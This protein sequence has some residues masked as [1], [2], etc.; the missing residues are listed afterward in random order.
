M[1][2]TASVSKNLPTQTVPLWLV[3]MI[4]AAA[5]EMK[6]VERVSQSGATTKLKLNTEK[7]KE[8]HEEEEEEELLGNLLSH[9]SVCPARRKDKVIYFKSFLKLSSQT[10]QHKSR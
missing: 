9:S 5:H 6:P 2:L 4:N 7:Q 10:F 3:E 1:R 8:G